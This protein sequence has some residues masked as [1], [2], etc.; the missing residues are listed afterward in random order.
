MTGRRIC[1]A[2]STA[3]A[4]ALLLIATR[5]IAQTPP[6]D[7][8]PIVKAMRDEM[9][10]S[11]QLRVISG[12]DVPY[13]FSYD[14]TDSENLHV[15]ATLG[16]AVNVTRQHQRFPSVEVRVGD[17]AFDNTD[18][19]FSG[20]SASSRYDGSWPLDDNYQNLRDGFWLATDHAYK[21]ALESMGRKRASLKNTASPPDPLPDYS[22]ADPLVSLPKV[23]HRKVDDP[24]WTARVAKLSGVFKA[25]PEI[26]TSSLE[27]QVIDGVTDLVNSEGTAVRYSDKVNWLQARADSQA[28]DGMYLRDALSIAALD[29]DKFPADAEVEKTLKE[30]GDHVRAL[31]K[32]PVGSSFTGPTLFEPEAAAQLLAQL[33]GDNLR[34]PRKPLSDPG[35]NINFTPSEFETRVGARVLPEWM[36]VIDDPTQ[37]TYEGKPLMGYYTFDLEGVAPKPVAA[38]EKGTLKAFLTTRQ[39]I[40]GFPVS[41]GHSRLAGSFGA[42]G[43]AIGNMIV[44]ANETTPLADLK[45]RLIDTIQ[46]RNLPYGMLVRKL[47]YPF[48]GGAGDL[49]ALRQA[50]QQAGARAV[51]PPLLVYRVY[52]D[53]REE[54]VRGMRFRGL[55]TR[56][57]RD[58]LAATRETALFSFINNGAPL[59][60]MNQGG[61]VAPTSVVSPGLLFDE[62]E[63]EVPTEQLSKP[64]LVPPPNA[65]GQ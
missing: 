46:Q 3:A 16:S 6:G 40:K 58:I 47:D 64:A 27:L 35:R 63:F 33:I 51:S 32:A 20:L 19:I 59:A 29:L 11:R 5:G 38:I 41:N 1:L 31:L 48:S 2:A 53:G 34:V 22:K 36:D 7:D 10:R 61:Y 23:A 8:D 24:A 57:L 52:P 65:P 37:A 60:M 15:V 54:L 25:Y 18:H 45:K 39:P 21:V 30:M 42:T 9:D 44:K 14:M 17:Y 50:G 26:L 56:A 28:P 4:A 62:I 49:Q 55:S 12:Q 43:A 13:F